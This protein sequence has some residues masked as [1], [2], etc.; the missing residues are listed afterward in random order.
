MR[1][2]GIVLVLAG[3]FWALIAFNMDTT[4]TTE[5]HSFGSI[6]VP[7]TTVHN[8]GLMETRRNNLMFAGLTILVGVV[9]I[10]FGSLNQNKDKD[11]SKADNSLKPCR[12]C[13]EEIE[14]NALKCHFCG[15]NSPAKQSVKPD[16]GLKA[17]PFCAEKIQAA[18]LKCRY[19]NTELPVRGI[20]LKSKIALI[21]EG[22]AKYE[23]YAYVAAALGG[24][25]KEEGQPFDIHFKV[26]L[27]GRQSRVEKFEDLRQWF[28]DNLP[29][30]LSDSQQEIDDKKRIMADIG[31][32]SPS[33]QT[34]PPLPPKSI[35]PKTEETTDETLAS[36]SFEQARECLMNGQKDMAI[37]ILRDIVRRFP[38]T[39]AAAQAKRSLAPK[40][41][42]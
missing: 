40:P 18:A 16:N 11:S 14:A 25:L 7:S 1:I 39:K 33:K 19:C 8:I 12:F 38:K 42:S 21:N 3:V 35:A 6:Y 29:S 28:I 2:L 41:R 31:T 34:P 5:S 4:V 36:K 15:F 10:G 13:G 26:E 24:S 20:R 30:S 22:K 17:C 32:T 23:T 37:D 9:L 27:G